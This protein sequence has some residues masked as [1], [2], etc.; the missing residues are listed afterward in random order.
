MEIGGFIK[1]KILFSSFSFV[2]K[3]NVDK[4]NF[5]SSFFSLIR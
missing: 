1:K 5:N 2:L 3:K 4:E